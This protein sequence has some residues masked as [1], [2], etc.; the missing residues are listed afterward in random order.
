M[1]I[2]QRQIQFLPLQVKKKGEG[3]I[4]E[5]G[6]QRLE[7]T[8]RQHQYFEHLSRGVTINKLVMDFVAKGWLV[9]FRDLFHL[10][11][12]IVH[13]HWVLNPEFQS[14]FSQSKV[15]STGVKELPLHQ[16]KII[17][18]PDL[19]K[20]L[21]FFRKLPPELLKVF[22]Q[23]AT[24]REVPA[25]TRICKTGDNS[26]ELFAMING[27]LGVYKVF[28]DGKRQLMSTVPAGSVF[29][30]GG[31]LLGKPRGADVICLQPS[32]VAVINH[33]PE[34][35]SITN[36]GKAEALQRR[37]WVLQGLLASEVFSHIPTETLDSLVF[38][39]KIINAKEGEVLAREGEPG[40]SFFIIIQ[41]N[42][43]FTQKGKS[44]RALPQGGIFGEV[45]LMVSGG[46]RTATAHAQKESLLLQIDMAEFYELMSKHLILAKEIETIAWKR[47]ESRI[48]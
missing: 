27:T 22:V 23:N 42:I 8:A 11:D 40:S 37:F 33:V 2:E 10:L 44:L 45:A 16:G 39:G 29:G 17:A 34:F 35:E 46:T 28:P 6:G 43:A 47:W 26:R 30:E 7:I 31:F 48:A 38:A 12:A 21:P 18:N 25:N 4:L 13:N 3:F 24:V 15:S 1:W 9:S 20:T 14:Y 32:T 41:G 19:I 36:S 5:H